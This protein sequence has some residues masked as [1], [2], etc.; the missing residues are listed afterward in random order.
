[1]LVGEHHQIVGVLQARIER[2]AQPLLELV[3]PLAELRAGLGQ[4]LDGEDEQLDLFGVIHRRPH[5]RARKVLRG[6]H[7][8]LDVHATKQAAFAS[9][10]EVFD[11]LGEDRTTGRHHREVAH[12][13]GCEVLKRCGEDVGL[14]RACGAVDHA[15]KWRPL[16]L[17][18]EVMVCPPRDCFECLAIGETEVERRGDRLN[19]ILVNSA[20]RASIG[21]SKASFAAVTLPF[22]AGRWTV[23]RGT[24]RR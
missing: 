13:L 3:R 18:V 19:A 21:A 6:D 23:G 1:M 9:G 11:G 4:R 5:R 12:P 10:G 2:G 20:H 17:S 16:A 15:L 14:A 22:A 8:R 7:N 24:Q